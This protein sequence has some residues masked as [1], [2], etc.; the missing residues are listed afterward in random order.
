MYRSIFHF[1][2]L[3]PILMGV[4]CVCSLFAGCGMQ[5]KTTM[6]PSREGY[7]ITIGEDPTDMDTRWAKYFY[8]HLNKR[9]NT[10]ELVAFGVSE[11]DMWRIIIKID[12]EMQD[13]F[14]IVCKGAEIRLTTHNSKQM[15]WLQYQ[16]IKKISQEDPRINGSDLPP[17]IINIKDTSGTFA[18][19]YQSVYS[20]T[21][22]NPDYVGVIGLDNFDDSW[23]IWGHNLRKVLIDSKAPEENIEKLYATI[24]GKKNEGQLCF[25]SEEMFRK[26]ESY[27]VD[28]FGEKNKT[29]FVIAPDDTPLACTCPSCIAIG[30]TEQNAT[31]AVTELVLRL[32]N[33][34]QNHFFY[35]TSYLST[36]EATDRQLPSN[37]GVMI[38]AIDFSLRQT[39]SNEG[40]VKKLKKQIDEWKNVTKNIYIWDYINNFDDYLTPFPVLKIAQQRL[41]LFKQYGVKGVFYNGSG[42]N[43]SALDEMKTY[44]LSALLINPDQSVDN[45][46]Q[47]FLNQEYPVAKKWLY[48]YYIGLENSTLSGKRLGLYAGIRESEKTFLDRDNFIK[49]YEELDGFVTNAKGKERKMLHELQ[50]A[51][52]F[53][54]LELGREHGFDNTTQAWEWIN[55]L[56]EHKAFPEMAYYNESADEI[57]YYIKEW[58]QYILATDLKK[59]NHFLRLNPSGTQHPDITD[60]NYLKLLTDGIHG[61]P[62]NYHFGWVIFPQQESIIRLPVK[63][64]N[65]SGTLYISFLNLPRH[66]FY[67]PLE[68]ELLKDGVSYKKMHPELNDFTKKGEMIKVTIPTD[69]K[70]AEQL[71]IKL[72]NSKKPGAQIGVDE[73]A[74]IQ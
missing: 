63:D 46:I 37:A 67:P 19:E 21:G 31:P 65:I 51:L 15:L 62:G 54:R 59:K 61:L 52:S 8:K 6:F 22:L 3:C 12:P 68:I 14:Q 5:A 1:D 13:D 25:S 70:G 41:K 72:T 2:R 28:N 47:K 74:F 20:P 27:I 42:Y 69:L 58:E 50:I 64:L 39:N 35:T 29:R 71:S 11:K 53:S 4:I 36:R 26:L 10:E 18:F 73:I 33:R 56:K 60:K 44:V 57:D 40:D 38:S 55:Q 7:L 48:D 32:S 16:L 30:N 43:Y 9:S 34:F 24:N 66:R 23:G 45:L 49:F 17:A